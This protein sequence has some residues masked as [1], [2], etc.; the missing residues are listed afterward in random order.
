MI[1][2]GDFTAQG[3]YQSALELLRLAPR[4]TAIFA[5]NHMTLVGCIR[6]VREAGLRIPDDIAIAGFEGFRDSGFEF[7]VDVPLTVNEHPT[8]EMATAA[9]DLL[10]EQIQLRRTGGK[11]AVRR[12][13]LKTHLARGAA[14]ATRT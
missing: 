2:E 4:P 1:R 9:V 5:A 3:R 10:M 12:L 6:A 14:A 7:L 8:R 13:V 11:G